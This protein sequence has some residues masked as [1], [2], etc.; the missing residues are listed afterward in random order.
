MHVPIFVWLV[1]V[2]AFVFLRIL[3]RF[4]FASVQCLDLSVRVVCSRVLGDTVTC[5]DRRCQ[6]DLVI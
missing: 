5:T 2:H 6:C 1:S 4:F 3:G